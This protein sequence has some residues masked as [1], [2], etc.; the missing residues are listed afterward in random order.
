MDTL[1]KKIVFFVAFHFCGLLTRQN[2][3]ISNLLWVIHP[4]T[5]KGALSYRCAPVTVKGVLSYWC[6]PVT[7]KGLFSYG[8]AH[9]TVKGVY[10]LIGVLPSV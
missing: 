8:C 5:V 6:A 1:P 3:D 10:F 9:V 4:A 7:V 2:F